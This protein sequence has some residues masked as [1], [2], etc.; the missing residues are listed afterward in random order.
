MRGEENVIERKCARAFVRV[1]RAGARRRAREGRRSAAG[2]GLKTLWFARRARAGRVAS[3]RRC[4][5]SGCGIGR[6]SER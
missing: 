2:V 3:V 4:G 6:W 1:V 5:S